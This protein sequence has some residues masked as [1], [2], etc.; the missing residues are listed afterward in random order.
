MAKVVI[1]TEVIEKTADASSCPF[2]GSENVGISSYDMGGGYKDYYVYCKNCKARGPET[3]TIEATPM[4]A[5]IK[6]NR[7]YKNDDA[8]RTD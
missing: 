6:W 5:V 2:C 8:M 1:G 3:C 7:R 4:D